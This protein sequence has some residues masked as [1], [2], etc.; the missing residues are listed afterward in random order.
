MLRFTSELLEIIQVHV[1]R[2]VRGLENGWFIEIGENVLRCR[3]VGC[4]SL[5]TEMGYVWR[6]DDDISKRFRANWRSRLSTSFYL[7]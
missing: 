7:L 4:R 3:A 5:Q 2:R 6:I 1:E